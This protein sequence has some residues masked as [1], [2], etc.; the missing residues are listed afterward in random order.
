MMG[1]RCTE[2]GEIALLICDWCAA[3]S[4]ARSLSVG[5]YATV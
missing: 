4:A 3:V 5:E 1:E 2:T